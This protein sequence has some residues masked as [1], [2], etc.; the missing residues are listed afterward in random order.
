[1]ATRQ[2]STTV[3]AQL[4]AIRIEPDG[5]VIV[6][7][8]LREVET[9]RPIQLSEDLTEKLTDAEKTRAAAWI[10]RAQQWLDAKVAP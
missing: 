10:A 4:T 5:R 3:D 7:A 8:A 1:M 2:F 9:G 6:T